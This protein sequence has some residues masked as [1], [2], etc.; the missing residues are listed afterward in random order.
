VLIGVTKHQILHT[1][2]IL[3]APE[4]PLLSQPPLRG[5]VDGEYIH[6]DTPQILQVHALYQGGTPILNLR[7]GQRIEGVVLATNHLERL[8]QPFLGMSDEPFVVRTR[9]SDV[10]IVIPG[11]KPLMTDGANHGSCPEIITKAMR[12]TS[13]VDSLQNAEY[14]QL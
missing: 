12:P 6:I 7:K 13:G 10:Q 14:P 9:H 4:V 2:I 5:P 1:L 8:G 3:I 11:D